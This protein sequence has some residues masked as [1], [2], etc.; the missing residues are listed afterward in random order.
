MLHRQISPPTGADPSRS[1]SGAAGA[2]PTDATAGAPSPTASHE[3]VAAAPG[4]TAVAATTVLATTTVADALGRLMVD[5]VARGV[6]HVRSSLL[7]S[8]GEIAISA[9]L[10]T[11][12]AAL[13]FRA[14]A[15]YG[16]RQELLLEQFE[17]QRRRPRGAPPPPARAPRCSACEAEGCTHAQAS[18]G[19]TRHRHHCAHCGGSFC[20]PHVRWRRSVAHKFV[21][22][23]AADKGAASGGGGGGG[24]GGYEGGGAEVRVCWQCV[25][26]LER[27]LYEN[28]IAERLCRCSDFIGGHLPPYVARVEDS[29]ADKVMRLG[30]IGLHVAKTLPLSARASAAVYTLDTLRKYGRIGLLGIMLKDDLLGMISTLR[31]M[32]GGATKDKSTA[33]LAAALYYLMARR[34]EARGNEPE[35]EARA[36][37][38]SRP[39]SPPELHA[40]MVYAPIALYAV[41]CETL[42]EMQRLGATHGY[43][44][45]FGVPSSS[46]VATAFGE[47]RRPAFALYARKGGAGAKG[48]GGEGRGKAS[49]GAEAGGAAPCGE[50]VLAIRGTNDLSDVLIDANAAGVPFSAYDDDHSRAMAT[51][52]ARTG[53][54][55][56]GDLGGEASPAEGDGD[57]DARPLHGWAHEGM[58][59]AARWLLPDVLTP[60]MHLHAS[61][62]AIVLC[63]HSLGA[64]IAAILTVLLR[65][66]I[67]TVR[68]VGFATP[69][70]LAGDGLLRAA[71]GFIE[72][73]SHRHDVVPRLTVQSVR[74]LMR[75]LA[76]FDAWQHDIR[77]DCR[78]LLQRAKNL[79]TPPMRPAHA[80]AAFPPLSAPPLLALPAPA[81]PPVEAEAKAAKAAEAEAKALEEEAEAVVA[82]TKAVEAAATAAGAAAAAAAAAAAGAAAAAAAAAAAVAAAAAAAAGAASAASVASGPVEHIRVELEHL[83]QMVAAGP[84]EVSEEAVEAAAAE[85]EAAVEAADAV[86]RVRLEAAHEAWLDRRGPHSSAP[87]PAHAGVSTRVQLTPRETVV[88]TVRVVAS[89]GEPRARAV[90]GAVMAQW[91]RRRG[92]ERRDDEPR[93]C[94]TIA[95]RACV[96]V[97]VTVE[98]REQGTVEPSP[99]GDVLDPISREEIEGAG[100][101]RKCL[102]SVSEVSRANLAHEMPEVPTLRIPGRVL[103]LYTSRGVYKGAWLESDAAYRPLSTIELAPHMVSNHQAKEYL[104]ALK[105]TL[106]AQLAPETAPAWQP[107]AAAGELCACC[108]APFTW[109]QA[110]SL[111]A[112]KECWEAQHEAQHEAES[113]V[114]GEDG[115]VLGEA[116]HE[117]ESAGAAAAAPAVEAATEAAAE[118]AA[119]AEEAALRA[120][121]EAEATRWL[122]TLSRRAHAMGRGGGGDGA[123]A[124]AAAGQAPCWADQAPCWADQAPLERP[125]PS[126]PNTAPSSPSTAPPSPIVAAASVPSP[127]RVAS[128]AASTPKK[129]STPSAMASAPTAAAAA[130]RALSSEAV[131]RSWAQMACARH[132]CR[133]CGR[134]VCDGCS[135]ERQ[136][137]PRFGIIEPVRCCDAC[138]FLL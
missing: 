65:P 17:S 34:R 31:A 127:S 106:A 4:G 87:P 48:G 2:A 100:A 129:P 16:G 97:D 63:G 43:Q 77:Q 89:A 40:L 59:E 78:G 88:A 38:G 66:L 36:F 128:T 92:G 133:A 103:H 75:Q 110:G 7:L 130:P 93:V 117:A 126:S 115:A 28:T 51:S 46:A 95:L 81:Q 26:L 90:M 137:L 112:W 121:A 76:A 3:L 1:G 61:G 138:F 60:L 116:Q 132:H 84:V 6:E 120:A 58:L 70:V 41:Y 62:Y 13:A 15:S 105:A 5:G 118:A 114:L 107:Y 20:A 29:N 33:S 57:D 109:E 21:T 30:A 68:C 27:E 135:R 108:A 52:S 50:A 73:V 79:W 86:A 9:A 80:V 19:L 23:A 72:S 136:A 35:A 134:V 98:P 12:D 111:P 45:L 56:D 131:E 22:T 67:P 69:P 37:R 54:R 39:P 49:S 18:F 8:V 82:E 85:V 14:M 102:G 10:R 119:E 32:E 44:F 25:C 123:E 47:R 91:W 125:P 83:E 71:G 122:E 99:A 104:A 113:A 42:V 24:G 96:V 94:V 64:G 124:E 55:H 11:L 101:S 74:V 53:R